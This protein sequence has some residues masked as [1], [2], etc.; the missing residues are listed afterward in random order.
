[1]QFATDIGAK[2]TLFEWFC[3]AQEFAMEGRKPIFCGKADRP[4]CP[5]DRVRVVVKMFKHH[6]NNPSAVYAFGNCPDGEAH[7]NIILE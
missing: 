6:A 3:D 5:L 2:R 1:L 4:R 7:P